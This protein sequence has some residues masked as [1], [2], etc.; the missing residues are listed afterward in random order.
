MQGPHGSPGPSS[1]ALIPLATV[2]A[3]ASG[4]GA[5]E[6]PSA[7]RTPTT[8]RIELVT[9]TSDG[10]REPD[11]RARQVFDYEHD[12]ALY[13]D[14]TTGCRSIAVGDDLYTELS[15]GFELPAGKRWVRYKNDGDLSDPDSERGFEEISAEDDAQSSENVSV[16]TFKLFAEAE[17]LPGRR[18]DHLRRRGAQIQLVGD[19]DLRG[20]RTTHYR[21]FVDVREQI[22]R[23]V[24]A[25]GWKPANVDRY[26]GQVAEGEDQIDIWVGSDGLERRVVT[27][28]RYADTGFGFPDGA[29]VTTADYL[30]YG[31]EPQIDTPPAAAV[32]SSAEFERLAKE[33]LGQRLDPAAPPTCR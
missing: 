3:L 23:A 14:E 7:D 16:M 28:T 18:L 1:R 29:S 27:T 19:E 15:E 13:E 17:P 22:R 31:L 4:C 11:I 2:L 21:T 20:E 33:Q 9:R 26:V 12:R 30:D 5:D 24:E 6:V 32:V 25:A 10:T 8:V